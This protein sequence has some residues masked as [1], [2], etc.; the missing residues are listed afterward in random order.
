M[1]TFFAIKFTQLQYFLTRILE[2]VFN[3]NIK[4]N[5]TYKDFFTNYKQMPEIFLPIKSVTPKS[6]S[7]NSHQLS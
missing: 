4:S 3:F 5:T 7:Q 1:L 6:Q 2:K